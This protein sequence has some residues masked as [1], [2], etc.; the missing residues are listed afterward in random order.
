MPVSTIK[1]HAATVGELGKCRGG[2]S[3]CWTMRRPRGDHTIAVVVVNVELTA[4]VF[5]VSRQRFRRGGAC[6]GLPSS[7]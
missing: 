3:W 4:L 6:G 2:G 7:T 5:K 1:T